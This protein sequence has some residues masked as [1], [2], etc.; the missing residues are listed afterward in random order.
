MLKGSYHSQKTKDTIGK[1][2]SLAYSTGTKKPP[3]LGKRAWNKGIPQTEETKRKL[4]LALKGRIISEETKRKMSIFRKGKP[5]LYVLG[6]KWKLSEEIK[7]RK[8]GANSY[9]WIK[10][11]SLLVKNEKK[12]LDVQYREWMNSVKKRD[13]WTCR[14]A[15]VNCDGRLE[16]HHI[17]N[18][19]DYPELRY[20]INNG[21]TL[22]HAHHPRGRVNEAKLSPFFQELVAEGKQIE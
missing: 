7:D 15:D 1:S 13:N 8:R 22:C 6:K 9:R 12:H 5:N 14:I 18:W 20:K 17:L 4:S 10:D 11:R 21:I 2:L 16:A 3:N 19:K